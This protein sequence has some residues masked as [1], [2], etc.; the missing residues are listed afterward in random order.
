VLTIINA[1]WQVV[2][3]RQGPESLPDSK[4][5]LF[6]ATTAYALTDCLIVFS[7]ELMQNWGELELLQ[8]LA[9]MLVPAVLDIAL[10]LVSVA[11]ALFYFGFP[12]RLRQTFTAVVG[13]TALLQVLTWPFFVLLIFE[14]FS[15]LWALAIL[16]LVVML[17]WSIAIFSHILSR[18][19]DRSFGVGVILAV[20]YFF[21]NY[22][23]FQLIPDF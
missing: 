1:F 13:T 6:I 11:S 15:A 10:L 7:S 16:A 2:L 4:P 12:G 21:V 19:I 9:R 3:F 23:M 17:L 14:Q 5:L 20:S 8:I 22:Q 18:A